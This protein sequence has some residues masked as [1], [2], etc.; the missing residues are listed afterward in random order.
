MEQIHC[1]KCKKVFEDP[2]YVVLDW[3]NAL[4]HLKCFEPNVNIMKATSTY[5]A[6]KHKYWFLNKQLTT[7]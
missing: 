5:E 4:F 2:D 6:I 1:Y 7:N 3:T